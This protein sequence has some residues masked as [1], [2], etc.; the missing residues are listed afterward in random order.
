MKKKIALLLII[1]MVGSWCLYADGSEE[2][3]V[4][5]IVGG[6]L[7]VALVIC[8]V[9]WMVEVSS[10]SEAPNDDSQPVLA[11]SGEP[12]LAPAA[13]EPSR[14]GTKSIGNIL[15]NPMLKHSMFGVDEDAVFVGARF[16]F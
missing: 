1:L 2:V 15:N 12:S 5:P 8:L 10:V 9:W 3:G 13:I 7:G 11:S 16:S 6:I 14:P 4:G